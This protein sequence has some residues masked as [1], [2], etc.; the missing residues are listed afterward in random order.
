MIQYKGTLGQSLAVSIASKYI[1]F[2]AEIAMY[3]TNR[4]TLICQCN[5]GILAE[6]LHAHVLL[7]FAILKAVFACKQGQG[8]F[9][10]RLAIDLTS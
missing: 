6:N 1:V 3:S 10:D 8:I 5:I 2:N 4:E 7:Y 9:L